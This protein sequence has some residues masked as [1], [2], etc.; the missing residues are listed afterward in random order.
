[1][2]NMGTHREHAGN[3]QEIKNTQEDTRNM[4]NMGNMEST[5][6]AHGEHMQVHTA[7]AV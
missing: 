5:Q 2:E 1:M 4:E 3:T 6:G 7:Y